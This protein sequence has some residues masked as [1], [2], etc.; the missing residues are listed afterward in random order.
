[1][2]F[3]SHFRFFRLPLLFGLVLPPYL[4]SAVDFN[5]EVRPILSNNCF[6]CHGPDAHERKADLRLDTEK[7]ATPDLGGYAALIP[8]NLDK[9]EMWARIINQDPDEVMPP[10]ESHK[11]LK[12]RE[13]QILRQWIVEGAK[14]DKY[15]AYE[16]PRKSPLPN[17]GKG[18]S[19]HWIDRFVFGKLREKG[20]SPSPDADRITLA[21][22]LHFD[23]TGLP[24][25]TAEVESF[26]ED[27]RPLGEVVADRVDTPPCF[28]S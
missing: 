22:R 11:K 28:I 12:P 9:S 1:M 15:W 24:P 7:G 18:W 13:R 23:L 5:A 3:S 6:F 2:S 26:V 14:Y 25:R 27:K 21:R 17:E 8:G 4:Y 16:Q 19:D 10:P 20:M